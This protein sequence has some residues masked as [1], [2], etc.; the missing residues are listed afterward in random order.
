VLNL[1]VHKLEVLVVIAAVL[2]GSALL[3]K[4]VSQASRALRGLRR[5]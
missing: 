4:A 3:S 1:S 5:R 2:A